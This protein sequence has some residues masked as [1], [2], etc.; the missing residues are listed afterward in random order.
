MAASSGELRQSAGGKH[1]SA[2]AELDIT[3][4]YIQTD[5]NRR[6]IG[7]GHFKST[8]TLNNN[9]QPVLS[10]SFSLGPTQGKRPVI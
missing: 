8:P 5:K 6:Y 1:A 9:K 3:L 7:Q 10:S 2:W 4:V